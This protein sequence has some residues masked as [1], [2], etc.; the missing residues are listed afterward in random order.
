MATR[1]AGIA[2]LCLAVAMCIAAA[3]GN[4]AGRRLLSGEVSG[5]RLLDINVQGTSSFTLSAFGAKGQTP[6]GNC[7]LQGYPG[8]RGDSTVAGPLTVSVYPGDSTTI[9]FS[10]GSDTS[11]SNYNYS[12]N[13]G[14]VTVN[15][16]SSYGLG[17]LVFKPQAV[18]QSVNVF[19]GLVSGTDPITQPTCLVNITFVTVQRP[20]PPPTPTSTPAPT[21]SGNTCSG[22]IPCYCQN[23]YCFNNGATLS[24]YCNPPSG[25]SCTPTTVSPSSIGVQY[26]FGYGSS[27][28][29]CKCSATG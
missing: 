18:G 6:G 14:V 20:S 27:V 28:N 11:F 29:V 16:N 13:V 23:G 3:D 5:R 25:Q 1:K 26:A 12:G 2:L 8:S 24:P 7:Y 21:T 19:S 15:Q 10:R 9:Y 4:S 17:S 22:V